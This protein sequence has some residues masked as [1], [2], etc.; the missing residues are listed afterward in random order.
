MIWAS[1]VLTLNMLSPKIGDRSWSDHAFVSIQWRSQVDYCRIRTWHLD[2]FLLETPGSLDNLQ[3]GI[4]EFY[5]WNKGT[6]RTTVLWDMCKAFLRGK[7]ISLKAFRVKEKN[8]ETAKLKSEIEKLEHVIKK[9]PMS[10]ILKQL[11]TAYEALKLQ[12][13]HEIL[14]GKQ[15]LFEC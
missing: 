9:N 10:N 4:L 1:T 6:A 13:A 12:I 5:S 14:A 3:T 15:K 7:L 2:N 11:D 8:S